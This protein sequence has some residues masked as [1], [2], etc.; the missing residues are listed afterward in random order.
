MSVF[1][2]MI[3]IAL[4]VLDWASPNDKASSGYSYDQSGSSQFA[5]R[6]VSREC[7]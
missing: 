3:V 4:L 2:A 7:T 5:G 1:V 6:M